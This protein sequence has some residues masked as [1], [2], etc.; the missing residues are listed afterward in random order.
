[1]KFIYFVFDIFKNSGKDQRVTTINIPINNFG[2]RTY[3]FSDIRGEIELEISIVG[4]E[5]PHGH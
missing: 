3:V 5:G 1:M 4:P 2:R